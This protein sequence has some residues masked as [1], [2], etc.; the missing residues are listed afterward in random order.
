MT[1]K[2]RLILS[3]VATDATF[4]R[5]IFQGAP[6]F[7]GRC[8]HCNARLLV[9]CDGTP[10]GPATIEHIVPRNHGG[11]DDRMNLALACARCNAE[12]GMR[13]DHKRRDDAR[14]QEVVAKLAE[15]RR[16]RWRDPPE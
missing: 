6:A 1:A 10:I 4:A 13:H 14:R 5:V 3:I 9:G 11:T 12:K 7:C 15:R 2:R 8:I 16:A